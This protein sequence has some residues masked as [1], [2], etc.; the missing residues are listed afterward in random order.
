MLLITHDLG[1]V[2]ET[3]DRVA[4]MYAGEI[5]EYGTHGGQCLT[6][7]HH[8]Y[9]IGLFG[10]MPSLERGRRSGSSPSTGL[11]P[12]P[13]ELPEGCSLCI[14]AAPTAT[15]RCRTRKPATMTSVGEQPDGRA[16]PPGVE[17]PN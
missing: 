5:V 4:I 13:T 6:T 9:T 17:C 16:C 14:P 3:C 12:D 2:A 7:A 8:P 15:E 11:M 1:V 10:S